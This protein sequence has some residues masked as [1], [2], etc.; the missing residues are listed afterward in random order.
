VVGHWQDED[1]QRADLGVWARA[2]CGLARR[3]GRP[4]ARFGDNMREVAVTEGDKVEAQIRG[5]S[6]N[7]Y[8]VGDLVAVDEVT[9]RRRGRSTLLVAEYDDS[10]DVAPELRRGRQR[11][12]SLRDGARIELGMRAFLEEGGFK[13][14]TTTFEDLTACAA[15]GPGR[16]AAD[17]RRLR[18]RGRGRLEDRG[19]GPRDEGHGAGLPGGTSLHGGLHL[20]PRPGRPQGPRRAHARGLPVDRRET[21]SLEVHPLG[22]GGKDDPCRLVFNVPSRPGLNASIIDMGNRFRM[23]VN[24]VDVVRPMRRCPSCRWPAWSGC[25]SPT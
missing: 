7:G 2:A 15:A 4:V 11:H 16:P 6:V 23:I 8:G 13:A 19:P 21:P 12:E 17:G 5:Y 9:D 22:I 3:A 10:Y 18:L 20:P 25:P 24:E 14:F 1:V